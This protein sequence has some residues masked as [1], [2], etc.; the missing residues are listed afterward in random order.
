MS[1]FRQK[2]ANSW[3]WKMTNWW[4]EFCQTQHEIIE[5]NGQKPEPRCN[6]CGGDLTRIPNGFGYRADHTINPPKMTPEVT[7]RRNQRTVY[8]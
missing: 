3:Q 4:C 8:D 1:K 7:V 2:V 5:R 6:A